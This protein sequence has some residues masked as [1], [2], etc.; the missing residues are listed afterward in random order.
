MTHLDSWPG[1]RGSSQGELCLTK[2]CYTA[3]GRDARRGE[4]ESE[5]EKKKE[6]RKVRGRGEVHKEN[7]MFVLNDRTHTQKQTHVRTA[8]NTTT[9]QSLYVICWHICKNFD[10][11]VPENLWEHE[12]KVITENME[13][14]TAHV[15]PTDPIEHEHR[16]QSVATRYH[17]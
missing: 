2:L 3:R 11:P 16:K 1:L 17:T 5:Y 9:Q 10:V 6:E 13:V 15:R 14:P 8:A 12:P 7:C 4:R